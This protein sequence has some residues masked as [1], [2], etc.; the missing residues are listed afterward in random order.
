VCGIVGFTHEDRFVSPE[1][2]RGAT[3][4]LIH[5]GPDQQDVYESKN[6]SLGAVRLTIIDLVSGAQ[7][8]RSE[9]GD[10]VLVFNGEVYN[11]GELREELRALGHRF[12]TTSDTEVVLHAFI[13][14]DTDCFRRLRGMFGLALWSESRKRLVLARDRM[15]IKPVYFCRKGRDVYFSSELKG[16]LHHPDID[17]VLNL[18]GLNCYLRL[19]YVPAPYTLVQG[20]EKLPPGQILVWQHG[21]TTLESYWRCPLPT[22]T[23]RRWA[24]ESAKEELDSLL[25]QSIKEHLVADVP[26]GLWASGGLDSSTILHYAAEA[27]NRPLKTFSITFKGRS[28]DE[29]AY[30]HEVAKHYGT[31]HSE[32]DLSVDMDLETAIQEFAY[33]SDE[34]SADAGCL[35]V[36]YLA[37]MSSEQVTVALSGEGADELLGGYLT[38]LASRYAR[39]ARIVPAVMRRML[40]AGLNHW[41]VSDDKIS[42]EYRLKRFLRGSLLPVDEAHIFWNGTFSEAEKAEFLVGA[43]S[44]PI[45]NILRN[46]P[47][48]PA[49][50]RYMLFDQQYYLADDIL[51]KADRMSMAHSLEVRPPFL[52]HRIVE[53]AASLPEDYKVRGSTLKFLLKELMK[54]KL[55]D[56]ILGRKKTGFDIPAHDWFRN[57]LK[58]LL[59]DTLTEQAIKDSQVFRWEGVQNVI[60]RHMRRQESLGYHLWGLLILFLWIKRWNIQTSHAPEPAEKSLAGLTAIA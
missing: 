51:Y 48:I 9:D 4:C 21:N 42:F 52:D 12:S 33:F 26:V 7:P 18:D 34:P 5:R 47:P 29:G 15:G 28:F 10:T 40:I 37:K 13:Q 23:N 54:G 50:N 60:Q 45:R 46:M 32:I 53:F 17:R 36:W 56:N 39:T 24:I 49:I 57:R 19:N 2:I 38:Y 25:R 44:A 43:S 22:E 30:I 14:W 6:V 16:I 35:P 11:H 58:P 41:P 1:L 3:S 31:D 55:P 27:S 20:I 59:L 8:M